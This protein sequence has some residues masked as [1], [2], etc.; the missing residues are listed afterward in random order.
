MCCGSYDLEK[1]KP[2]AL[3]ITILS[4]IVAICG[5]VMLAISFD[6][7]NQ[8]DDIFSADMGT[9]DEYV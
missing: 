8:E 2:V 7:Y 4:G 6:F 3:V 5:I 9:K 1:R